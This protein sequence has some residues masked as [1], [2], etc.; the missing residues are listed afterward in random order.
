MA[1]SIAT[2]PDG[3]KVEY[4][5]RPMVALVAYCPPEGVE[6]GRGHT[7]WQVSGWRSSLKGAQSI[8]SAFGKFAQY[9]DWDIRIIEVEAVK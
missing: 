5:G 1:Q 3:Q 6:D 7:G 9:R 8:V 4:K 2:L